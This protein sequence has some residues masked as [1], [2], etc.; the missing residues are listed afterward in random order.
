MFGFRTSLSMAAPSGSFDCVEYNLKHVCCD[1]S[2]RPVTL[3]Q[4]L[5][6]LT[7]CEG[8][9]AQMEVKFSQEN[10]E[11]IWMKNNLPI[12]ASNRVHIVIDKQIHKLLIEDTNK[13][14]SGVYSFEVPAQEISTS[15]KLLIQSKKP[16]VVFQIISQRKSNKLS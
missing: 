12:E 10:V 13:N 5:C 11:G 16:D 3:M 14:D 1:F 7:I 9:I 15:A 8:E 6:D 4:P 2:V